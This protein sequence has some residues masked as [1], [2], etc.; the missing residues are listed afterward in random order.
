MH[1]K[2]IQLYIIHVS[3]YIFFGSF[4][5]IGYYKIWNIIFPVAYSKSLLFISCIYVCILYICMYVSCIYVCILYVC[6]LYVCMYASVNTKLLTTLSWLLHFYRT[7]WR[8]ER[9]CIQ[10]RKER[11]RGTFL[12]ENGGSF[13]M[14]KVKIAIIWNNYYCF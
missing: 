2:V 3:F 11:G 14:V 13:H 8:K 5:T 6:I 7:V 9:G 10:G 12:T 1:S 4:S